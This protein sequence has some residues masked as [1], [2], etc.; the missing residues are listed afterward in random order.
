MSS[1]HHGASGGDGGRPPWDGQNL[2]LKK[3]GAEKKSNKRK[4]KQRSERVQQASQSSSRVP[5]SAS[6]DSLSWI[7]AMC[8]S[9]TEMPTGA[10]IPLPPPPILDL[11][12]EGTHVN[13]GA[14]SF[15]SSTAEA[16]ASSAALPPSTA[17]AGVSSG[18]TS[19]SYQCR[20]CIRVFDRLQSLERHVASEHDDGSVRHCLYCRFI[21][22]NPREFRSHELS[23][24]NNS[25]DGVRSCPYCAK[26]YL[27]YHSLAEHVRRKHDTQDGGRHCFECIFRAA[28]TAGFR[29]H[30]TGHRNGGRC[31][32]CHLRVPISQYVDHFNGCGHSRNN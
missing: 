23:H 31:P 6:N 21:S 11:F 8:Q 1:Y 30:R 27:N 26:S 19:H 12:L 9:G 14:P 3:G 2:G 18:P 25:G 24:R 15:P 22:R 16:S 28:D 32:K 10:P 13:T 29:I 5:S 4:E 7:E 20:H 17:E